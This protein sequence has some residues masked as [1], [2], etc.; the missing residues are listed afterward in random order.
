MPI[1]RQ[2]RRGSGGYGVR[3]CG[4]QT[5]TFGEGRCSAPFREARHA[6]RAA[7]AWAKGGEGESRLAE[8][9]TPLAAKGFFS[10]PDRALPE[11]V[12]NIDLL[13]VGRSGIYVIDAKDWSGSLSVVGASLRQND[14]PR[15]RNLAAASTYATAVSEVVDGLLGSGKI[16]TPRR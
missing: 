11:S 6:A 4:R 10:L 13:L 15:N 5:G 1:H 7:D 8:L 3:R 9:V 12:S 14:R 2:P 16:P